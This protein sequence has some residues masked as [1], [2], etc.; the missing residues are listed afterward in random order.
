MKILNAQQLGQV[1]QQTLKEQQISSWQLMERASI[2]ATQ[3]ILEHINKSAHQVIVLAGNRNNGGDGLS[4]AYHLANSGFPV[5]VYLF[6]YAKQPSGENA[7]NQKRLGQKQLVQVN[8]STPFPKLHEHHIIIDAIFGV[9]LS[10]RLPKLVEKWV[11][12]I[13]ASQARIYSIDVPSGLYL[14]RFPNSDEKVIQADRTFTFQLPK[15]PFLFASTASYAGDIE[16][17]DIG[18]SKNALDR[19][20]A[21]DHFITRTS[22]KSIL[23]KRDRFS[24]KGNYGHALLVGGSYGMSGSISLATKACMRSGVGK[25]TCKV[26]GSTLDIIQ[27][28]VPEAMVIP[29]EKA[30]YID[31]TKDISSYDVIGIGVGI[32]TKKKVLSAFSDHVRNAD[33]PM[34]IDADGINCLAKDKQLLYQL[35]KHSILTPHPGE[36]NRLVALSNDAFERKQ[37]L[38]DFAR[39]YELILVYK[40]AHTLVTDGRMT[41]FNSTGNPGMATAGS[42]DVLTGLITGLLAQAYTAIDAARLGVYVHGLAGDLAKREKGEMAMISSD[43]IEHLG[44]AF[45]RIGE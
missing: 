45:L 34:V 27:Q 43:I 4:I 33:Q 13:N 31:E 8:E 9:G 40:D 17:V 18:L 20:E 22:V 1:D 30:K 19:I 3:H 42:G 39:E 32:S 12:H 16:I 37:Q 29:S 6:N 23:K 11:E 10:R 35:P 24:H 44:A 21:D 5:K 26:P 15:L 36:M 28:S 7:K 41:Y 25:T 14:D 38:V 2:Q